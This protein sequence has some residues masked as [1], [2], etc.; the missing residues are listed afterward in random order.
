MANIDLE[1]KIRLDIVKDQLTQLCKTYPN[2]EYVM[3][4]T[5][6]DKNKEFVGGT[7]SVRILEPNDID[8]YVDI[9]TLK[10]AN[11]KERARF[12]NVIHLAEFR[13]LCMDDSKDEAI[14][15]LYDENDN[16]EWVKKGVEYMVVEV[17]DS[18]IDSSLCFKLREV[19]SSRMIVVP[20]PLDGFK[21]K[22][23]IPVKR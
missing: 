6:Y 3:L 14:T 21:S 8:I 15:E 9:L 5:M 22:R 17:F 12:M 16:K 1:M 19:G 11:F 4:A 7:N 10:K 23:F 13:V 20:Y 18:L 2:F